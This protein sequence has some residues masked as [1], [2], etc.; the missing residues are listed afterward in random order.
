MT[1]HRVDELTDM[2]AKVLENRAEPGDAANGS[3]PIRSDTNRMPPAAGS[4]R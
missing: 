1:Q 4:G 3:Q 2:F